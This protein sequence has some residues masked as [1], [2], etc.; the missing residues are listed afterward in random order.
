MGVEKVFSYIC[1]DREFQKLD[2]K[3]VK[4]QS[5]KNYCY[6]IDYFKRKLCFIEKLYCN[7]MIFDDFGKPMYNSLCKEKNTYKNYISGKIT[8]NKKKHYEAMTIILAE[9]K[10]KK[11]TIFG[12]KLGVGVE[13]EVLKKLIR[14]ESDGISEEE[15]ID[16]VNLYKL[17][18]SGSLKNA[19]PEADTEA[20]KK[21]LS[22]VKSD[23]F[24]SG[25]Y[26]T[27]GDELDKISS[28]FSNRE[29][30]NISSNREF[31][32]FGDYSY[33]N[34][35][36]ENGFTPTG[37]VQTFLYGIYLIFKTL[38]VIIKVIFQILGGV[39]MVIAS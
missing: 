7:V 13:I 30:D 19:S 8:F 9:G 16:V 2:K 37:I 33:I 18:E 32:E 6:I 5:K 3:F 25:D 12:A 4:N 28:D 36:L 10:Y 14:A 17:V 31:G 20:I 29:L 11:K 26:S 23:N 34:K 15:L 24:K 38:L 27:L 39:L 21:L 35:Y 1:D 22:I